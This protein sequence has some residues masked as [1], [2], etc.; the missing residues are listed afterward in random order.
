MIGSLAIFMSL[1]LVNYFDFIEKTQENEEIAWDVKTITS[2]D[3]TVE[4][5]IGTDFYLRYKDD[6]EKVRSNFE[7]Q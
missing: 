4:I 3:Y 7:R 1:F 6:F 2:G 5:D